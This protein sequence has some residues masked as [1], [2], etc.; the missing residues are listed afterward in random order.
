MM[1]LAEHAEKLGELLDRGRPAATLTV[2]SC[3]EVLVVRDRLLDALLLSRPRQPASGA[4][5]C[6]CLRRPVDSRARPPRR[7]RG[8]PRARGSCCTASSLAGHAAV[9][10]LAALGRRG[11]PSCRAGD[12]PA[13]LTALGGAHGA[14][15]RPCEPRGGAAPL[16]T[17]AAAALLGLL[18]RG[19]LGLLLQASFSCWAIW[20]SSEREGRDALR[21]V[22]PHAVALGLLG[23][24]A[25]RLGLL[26]P[27]RACGPP[28]RRRTA[29]RLGAL[30]LAA[31]LG[32]DGAPP[33]PSRPRCAPPRRC[34]LL[35]GPALRPRSRRR[36]PR[37]WAPSFLRTIDDVGVLER[38]RRPILAGIFMSL[39]C[40]SISLLEMP[41]SLARSC[42][43]VFA[44]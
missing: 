10:V 25:L 21:G 44:M 40:W 19:L 34:G 39:R 3:G 15:G 28:R 14:A 32:R 24:A 13:S 29:L 41:Y 22:V 16:A 9:A 36:A 17:R 7:R 6:G 23:R 37:G 27:P 11:D 4:A 42:T 12:R 30:S 38:G 2:S 20:S 8:P 33:R 18:L 43:R 1:S 5:P 35:L 31:L 26:R